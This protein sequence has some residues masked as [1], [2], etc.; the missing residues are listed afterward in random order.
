LKVRRGLNAPAYRVHQPRWAYSPTSG[1]GACEHGGRLNRP[2]LPALYLA[3]DVTTA[4]EEYRQLSALV[5]P[6][7]MVSY[8]LRIGKVVDF[9][10]GYT[11]SWEL[12]W[13]EL[14]CDWRRLWFNQHVEPPS[15]LLADAALEAG[16]V[17]ILF[18]SIANPDGTNL[19]LYTEALEA[20]DRLEAY[21][22][23]GDLPK[24][25]QSWE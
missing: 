2:G 19:V 23:T 18:P 3:L 9:S 22:P 8:E 14:T 25:Q 13:Q 15:W 24:N 10:G 4:L 6:G 20:S 5:R 12:L 11:R 21:D 16:A 7:L 17:G 1:A